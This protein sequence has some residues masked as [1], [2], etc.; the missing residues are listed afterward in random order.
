MLKFKECSIRNY[1]GENFLTIKELT[2]EKSE[3]IQIVGRNNSG[4]SLFCDF[5]LSHPNGFEDS[6]EILTEKP[7]I[8]KIG[9]NDNLI[10]EI[11]V[12]KNIL[13]PF[14]RKS[15]NL[16]SKIF[17]SVKI[18]NFED[19]DNLYP[20][21][22]SFSDKKII[23]IIRAVS[24]KPHLIIIDDFDLMFD[25]IKFIKVISLIENSL[26]SGTSF[27][28]TAKNKIDRIPKTYKIS[29]GFLVK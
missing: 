16:K 26:K 23:E 15:E 5:I 13:I 14:K 22:M 7:I 6:F 27:I 20:K 10:D 29:N 28:F 18:F 8:I 2:L 3:V 21:N 24:R 25:E 12:L 19:I 4:K 11:S 9:I 1:F 17:D